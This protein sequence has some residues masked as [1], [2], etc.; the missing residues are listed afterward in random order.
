ML[1]G[2]RLATLQAAGRE[3]EIGGSVIHPANREKK[4]DKILIFCCDIFLT[5]LQMF[6]AF[7]DPPL[8]THQPSVHRKRTPDADACAIF[9]PR[10]CFSLSE[11]IFVFPVVAILNSV[12]RGGCR[13]NLLKNDE[14]I[15]LCIMHVFGWVITF[16]RSFT[17]FIHTAPVYRCGTGSSSFKNLYHPEDLRYYSDFVDY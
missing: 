3:Y 9:H 1:V 15:T 12:E 16:W 6:H 2:G 7:N 5:H 14:T 13:K 4:P 17:I 8:H 10:S 11:S